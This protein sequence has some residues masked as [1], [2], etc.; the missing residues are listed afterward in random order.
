MTTRTK[1][2]RDG[3]VQGAFARLRHGEWPRWVDRIAA[4]TLIVGVIAAATWGVPRLQEGADARSRERM[5]PEHGVQVEFTESLEWLP[6]AECLRLEAAVRSELADRPMLDRAS[7][8]RAAAALEASGWF[9]PRVQVR[10][11]G[12][13]RVVVGASIRLPAAVVRVGR[14]DLVVDDARRLLPWSWAAGHA[15]VGSIAVVGVASP[16]PG[17]PGEVWESGDLS[18]ALDILRTVSSRPWSGQ[19]RELDVSRVAAGGPTVLRTRGG[20]SIVWGRGGEIGSVA[21][22]ETATKLAYLDRLHEAQ[23]DLE[24]PPH[25]AFDLRL[26]YLALVP[27]PGPASNALVAGPAGP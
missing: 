27:D 17:R 15:P 3:S 24:A 22:V 6:Q 4:A 23:G 16:P 5:A 21:E 7:L 12:R 10:R 1:T 19:L 25:R 13:D 11:A 18:A 8:E 2:S 14:S 20:S 9:E 26:D